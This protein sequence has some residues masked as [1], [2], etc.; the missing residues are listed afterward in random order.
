[1]LSQDRTAISHFFKTL[2]RDM[3]LPALDRRS[4]A[5][6]M[7]LPNMDMVSPAHFFKAISKNGKYISL[8]FGAKNRATA[9]RALDI[10]PLSLCFLIKMRTNAQTFCSRASN[11]CFWIRWNFGWRKIVHSRS[12]TIELS[13]PPSANTFGLSAGFYAA[14]LAQTVDRKPKAAPASLGKA[15]RRRLKFLKL[16]VPPQTAV[17]FLRRHHLFSGSPAEAKLRSNGITSEDGLFWSLSGVE[18]KP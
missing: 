17:I 12:F 13:Q 11:S 16:V 14:G 1:M 9:L 6:D 5:L 18:I 10:V 3:V 15:T 2:A 7:V 4:P 8:F